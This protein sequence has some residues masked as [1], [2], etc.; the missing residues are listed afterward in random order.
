MA[1]SRATQPT[2]DRS[3]R[4]TNATATFSRGGVC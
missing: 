4:E 3:E 2:A 1:P